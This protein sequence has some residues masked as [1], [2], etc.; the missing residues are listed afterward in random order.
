MEQVTFPV[1]VVGAGPAG[2]ATPRELC[3]RGIEHQVLERGARI[4]DSWESLYDTLV[5]HTGKH[6]SALPGM[7]FPS[8]TPLFPT[9]RQFIEYLNRYA[10]AFRLPVRTGCTV[11]DA[12]RRDGSWHLDTS[13]GPLSARA[14]FR[15]CSH[16]F[17]SPAW[18]PL[19]QRDPRRSSMNR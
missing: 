12:E 11:H 6:M 1:L 18:A 9:R 3:R 15:S 16:A 10:D 14:G 17:E 8:R 2:L 19:T 4:A 13:D 7:R 5:L